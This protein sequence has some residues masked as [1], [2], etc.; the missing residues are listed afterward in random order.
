MSARMRSRGYLGGAGVGSFLCLQGF[1][2]NLRP[3]SILNRGPDATC[4]NQF[5]RVSLLVLD[6]FLLTPAPVE[7][8]RDLLE[9]RVARDM[10]SS[11]MATFDMPARARRRSTRWSSFRS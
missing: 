9:H 6:D 3:S 5:G 4:L 1:E 11:P 2:R 10:M 7:A 8:C